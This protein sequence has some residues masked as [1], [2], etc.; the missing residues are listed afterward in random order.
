M[1]IPVA[2][3]ACV[4]VD[5]VL[6]L[7]QKLEVRG[8]GSLGFRVQGGAVR[9]MIQHYDLHVVDAVHVLFKIRAT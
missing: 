3:I 5:I 4:L 7:R 8:R 1:T 2:I 9:R 6:M